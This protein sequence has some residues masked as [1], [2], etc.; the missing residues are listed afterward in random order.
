MRHQVGYRIDD[1]E[2]QLCS[3]SASSEHAFQAILQ[4]HQTAHCQSLP[5]SYVWSSSRSAA[6]EAPRGKLPA[7]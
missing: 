2:L 5:W 3:C 7:T 4:A 6:L 1:E